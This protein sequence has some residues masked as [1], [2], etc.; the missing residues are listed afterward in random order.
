ML[1]HIGRDI[2]EILILRALQLGDLLCAIPAIRA[3]KNAYRHSRIVLIGLPWA[4]DF[5]DRFSRYFSGFIS[6]PGF[7][8]LIEQ[9]YSASDF[10]NFISNLRQRKADLFIQMHGNG[11]ISNDISV[12]SQAARLAGYY[13]KGGYRPDRELYMP[14]PEEVSEVRRHLRLMEFL[15]VPA[16]GEHLEFPVSDAE[17]ER[18]RKLSRDYDLASGGYVCIHP[19]ARDLRRRWDVAKFAAVADAIA[20]RGY[21]IVLTGAESERDTVH[22]VSAAMRCP[23]VDLCGKTGLGELALLIRNAR[24]LFANDTGVSHIAAAT[25]TSSIIVFLISDP[26]RWAPSDRDLHRTILPGESENVEHAFFMVDEV[27][28]QGLRKTGSE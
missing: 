1:K 18:Y 14:Y 3:L 4:A 27:L 11:T 22:K 12:M 16:A 6:F 26:A 15:G 25:G 5:A 19:G 2:N 9:P 17:Q 10:T 7:P 23:S 13:I 21:R 20:A 28:N 8:G 24:L